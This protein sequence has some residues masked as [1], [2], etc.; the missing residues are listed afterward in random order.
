MQCVVSLVLI[1]C[2]GMVKNFEYSLISGLIL[3]VKARLQYPSVCTII[4]VEWVLNLMRQQ[5]IGIMLCRHRSSKWWKK[6]T[7]LFLRA[8]A[9]QEQN[10]SCQILAKSATA[11][12]TKK[13]RGSSCLHC[14]MAIELNPWMVV[15]IYSSVQDMAPVHQWVKC[16][17]PCFLVFFHLSSL[18][19]MKFHK[20]QCAG[21]K[22][23]NIVRTQKLWESKVLSSFPVSHMS[24]NILHLS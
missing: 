2:A 16:C 1:E 6:G 14:S 19:E 10:E 9:L 3:K 8:K 12:A 13:N 22:L 17:L 24:F 21:V 11:R 18:I 5:F 20:K 4:R 7:A 15:N 23:L